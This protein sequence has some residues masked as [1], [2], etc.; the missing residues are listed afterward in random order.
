MSITKNTTLAILLILT[1]AASSILI[2]SIP[3]V[4]AT[5]ILEVP[6]TAYP[7]IQSAL[8]VAG[9]GAT[10][11]V[12][13]G[14]YN[15]T[16][17][18][19]GYAIAVASGSGKP[20]SGITLQGSTGTV[21]NGNVTLLYLDHLKIDGLTITGG[22]TLG[23]AGV[24]GCVRN[25][26]ISN[27]Q[28]GSVTTIGGDH[29]SISGSVLHGLILKGAD[30]RV[31]MPST[32]T[33]VE[34]NQIQCGIVIKAGSVSNTIKGNFI[35][36]AQVGV[37]EEP[38]KGYLTSGSNLLINNTIA[39]NKIG[40][41][42]YSAGDA[43]GPSHTTDKII[44]NI[45]R[46]NAVGIEISASSNYPFANTIYHNDFIS[47]KVQVKIN[48]PFSNTWDDAQS[49]AKGNYWSDYTGSDGNGDGVGD[50]PYVINAE[51]KDNYPLIKPFS[52]PAAPVT[53][54]TPNPSSQPSSSDQ[55]SNSAA[56]SPSGPT[57]SQQ[58]STTATPGQSLSV[59]A[60]ENAIPELSFLAV[61]A[62]LVA[63]PLVLLVFKRKAASKP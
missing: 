18:Y 45:I 20:V 28:V 53:T 9:D 37:L 48:Y 6:S 34:N 26:T 7:T 62:A 54:P 49:P 52:S 47:N 33:N 29:N 15:E 14:T 8:N 51:N 32:N 10:I 55:P 16:I 2:F 27:V 23:D 58:P 44:Q 30:A 63:V 40:I 11:K 38:S 5:A 12:A 57:G 60:N 43:T 31:Q 46:N 56:P 39:D 22:L 21:I 59:G 4:N 13:P 17:N 1:F 35:S 50:T 41:S 3:A 24:Y 61:L 25:S 36:N 42:L 19:D